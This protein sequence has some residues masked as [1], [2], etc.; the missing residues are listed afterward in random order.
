MPGQGPATV[1]AAAP[2]EAPGSDA[3]VVPRTTIEELVYKIRLLLLS[4]KSVL[5]DWM[6]NHA[7]LTK[8]AFPISA[9][10][11]R[12][13]LSRVPE[14]AHLVTTTGAL[15]DAPSPPREERAGRGGLTVEL[16]R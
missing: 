11:E 7:Q 15:G 4:F 9:S 2:E 1:A 3:I 12:I 8:L 16:A 6:G 10:W 5:Y 14:R 13:I